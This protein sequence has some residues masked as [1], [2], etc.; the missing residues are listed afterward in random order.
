[1]EPPAR[2]QEDAR[3]VCVKCGSPRTR[4]IGQSGEP[5][6]VHYRCEGCECVFSHPL[7]EYTRAA[8]GPP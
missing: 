2:V 6:L 8:G 5:P 7:D 3:H 1:M 4:I